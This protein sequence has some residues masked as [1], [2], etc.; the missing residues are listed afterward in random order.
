MNSR[1]T[2][3]TAESIRG[4]KH[5]IK[6]ATDDLEAH[7]DRIDEKLET[8]FS[9]AA[10]DSG[11][12]EWRQ[13]QED[14]LSTQ[15]CLQICAQLSEHISQIQLRPK[16]RSEGS[17]MESICAPERI[18]GEAM[19]ECKMRLD[20]ATAKLEGYMHDVINRL[21]IQSK[22]SMAPDE[23]ADLEWLRE[24]WSTARQCMDICFKA[25]HNL[26]E[27][28]SVIDNQATEDETVQFLVSTNEK[29]IHGK[30][31]GDGFRIRQIGGHLSDESLQQLSRD[32]AM[33]SVTKMRDEA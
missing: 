33:I 22:A 18:A 25:D 19:Q 4:Y 29:T 1:K 12:A 17:S 26:K 32:I 5:L 11:T 24:E 10:T 23:L 28:I 30:N 27:S 13:M 31:R 6:T 14:R 16:Q 9:R 2:S 15:Q 7:L 20:Q 21:M 3:V 8:I